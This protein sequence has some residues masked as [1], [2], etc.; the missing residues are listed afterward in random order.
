MDPEFFNPNKTYKQVLL[1]K[2]NA[3]KGKRIRKASFFGAIKA[4]FI[5]WTHLLLV[6]GMV[7]PK[8]ELR[9]MRGEFEKQNG[10]IFS[11]NL[12]WNLAIATGP[13]LFSCFDV[14]CFTISPGW[15]RFIQSQHYF[16][17][18]FGRNCDTAIVTPHCAFF[19][20]DWLVFWDEKKLFPRP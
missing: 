13:K 4:W 16:W 5:F 20:R 1:P 3:G 2:N 11:G 9:W 12:S 6:S 17:S 7:L 18:F 15:P 14:K 19:C 10:T 8:T